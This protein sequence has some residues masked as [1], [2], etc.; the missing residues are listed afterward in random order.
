MTAYRAVQSGASR[1][2]P[3]RD[4]DP[5]SVATLFGVLASPRLAA[6][7]PSPSAWPAGGEE[8]ARGCR[9]G[10]FSPRQRFIIGYRAQANLPDY[11]QWF[12]RLARALDKRLTEVGEVHPRLNGPTIT[13]PAG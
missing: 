2:T 1:L 11:A 7:A 13:T 6:A 5:G 9:A 10:A 8:I 12:E 3:P 4:R